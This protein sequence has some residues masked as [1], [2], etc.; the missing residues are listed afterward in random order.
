LIENIGIVLDDLILV[1]LLVK[2]ANNAPDP[3]TFADWTDAFQY[4]NATVR[5]FERQLRS[6]ASENRQKLRAIVGAGYRDLLG[7]ADRI[8]AM[9]VQMRT[10]EG[11]LADAGRLC[12]SKAV[13]AVFA[14]TAGFD[15]AVLRR[16]AFWL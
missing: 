8:V 6:H 4:P 3:R 7:T 9:D 11:H 1:P 14:N 5:Q 10:V 13:E 16:S 2:M 15:A 12:S